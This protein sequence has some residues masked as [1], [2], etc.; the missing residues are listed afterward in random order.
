M[1]DITRYR[2]QFKKLLDTKTFEQGKWTKQTYYK[3]KTSKM[4]DIIMYTIQKSAL[5]MKTF[6]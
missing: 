5:N 3:K 4:V 6:E 2:L 1:V